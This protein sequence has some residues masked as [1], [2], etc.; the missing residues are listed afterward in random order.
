[1]CTNGAQLLFDDDDGSALVNLRGLLH[2]SKR[3]E[4]VIIQKVQ[5]LNKIILNRNTK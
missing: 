2:L 4:R 5:G 3:N 1:M